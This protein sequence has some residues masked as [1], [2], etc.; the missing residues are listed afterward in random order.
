MARQSFSKMKRGKKR[1]KNSNRKDYT[2][3]TMAAL[4]S[5]DEQI[6]RARAELLRRESLRRDEEERAARKQ[7]KIDARAARF[8]RSES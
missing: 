5:P 7:A 4:R 6:R 8:N 2:A 1:N 3:A